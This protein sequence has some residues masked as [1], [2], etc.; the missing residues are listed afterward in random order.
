MSNEKIL[1][2][3]TGQGTFMYESELILW[4]EK[5]YFHNVLQNFISSSYDINKEMAA[6][7]KRKI[8]FQEQLLEII[9]EK[10]ISDEELMDLIALYRAKIFNTGKYRIKMSEEEF[11]LK[12][13]EIKKCLL[14][15]LSERGCN[16]EI[17]AY[18]LAGAI[19][20]CGEAVCLDKLFGDTIDKQ[21]KTKK[22]NL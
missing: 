7:Y 17:L 4:S 10:G 8:E 2:F 9:S 12:K 5:R 15:E 16:K 1:R 13:L 19:L 20:N 18:E 6:I 21:E 3:V 22:F 14:Y 11:Q